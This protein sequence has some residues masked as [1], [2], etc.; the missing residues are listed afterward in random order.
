[1]KSSRKVEVQPAGVGG[2]AAW[3][4]A[5]MVMLPPIMT[6]ADA[7]ARARRRIRVR[8]LGWVEMGWS[9]GLMW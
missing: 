7:A 9:E 2:A 1:L 8:G 4:D 3:A 5:A 6:I